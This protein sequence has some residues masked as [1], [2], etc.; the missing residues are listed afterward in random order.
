MI[1]IILIIA[2]ILTSNAALAAQEFEY[3][4]GNKI[5]A[6]ISASN[7]NR[8]EFGK[9]GIAQII[10]DE[11]KYK[12]IADSKAQNIFLLP[13]I[14][15]AQT[16]ELALV[17]FSGNVADLILKVE[18]MEGQIIK[19]SMD[20]F[21]NKPSNGFLNNS[22]VNNKCSVNTQEQEIAGM[23]RNM[24]ADKEGK[25]YVTQVKRKID[26]LCNIGLSI[27]QDRIYRFGKL[28]GARLVVINRKAQDL[29]HLKEADFS[30]LF[31]FC[32]ATT[33]D[34]T[35]LLPK[36]KG[37]VWIVAKEQDRD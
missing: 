11:S 18:D 5:K 16:L 3:I 9:I 15:V 1:K 19:I 12:I 22:A 30:N 8:I 31:D 25:Y 2:M 24:I 17:N 36:A 32:L 23:I 4:A 6:K 13:K 29:V 27:E 37:F 20:S 26:R 21:Y 33:I 10:G 28:I 14:P 35:I 34:K 7:V